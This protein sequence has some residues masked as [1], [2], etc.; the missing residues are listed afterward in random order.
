MG[1][2]VKTRNQLN[3]ALPGPDGAEG[4][5]LGTM[6]LGDIG[7]RDGLFMDIHSNVERARLCMADLRVCCMPVDD[8]MRFWF[9]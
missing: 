3:I 2:R 7:D 6:F 9:R 1:A 5:N 4:D 8:R